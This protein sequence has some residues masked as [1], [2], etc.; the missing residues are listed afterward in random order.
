[1]RNHDT[2][3]AC[4]S[5]TERTGLPVS[6]SVRIDATHAVPD[7]GHVPAP[8]AWK[9][10]DRSSG[11]VAEVRLGSRRMTAEDQSGLRAGQIVRLD[12]SID[13]PVEIVVGSEVVAYGEMVIVDGRLAI[14]VAEL[15]ASS[16]STRR[17][18][19]R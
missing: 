12:N 7:A 8:F 16:G 9:D 14:Q 13:E 19:I 10:L 17:E 5:E 2:P 11:I 15:R 1:M 3:Q 18:V 4:Q 6:P